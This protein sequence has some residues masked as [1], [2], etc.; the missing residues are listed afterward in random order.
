MYF[1][2]TGEQTFEPEDKLTTQINFVEKLAAY[3]ENHN[4]SNMVDFI[5]KLLEVDPE[6]RMSAQEALGHTWLQGAVRNAK[7]RPPVRKVTCR[8]LSSFEKKENLEDFFSSANSTSSNV[9]R[10]I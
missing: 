8:S 4:F 6:V 1:L 2:C 10:A 5:S 3:S 7:R 9:Q